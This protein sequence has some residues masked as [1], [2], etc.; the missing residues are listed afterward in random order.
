MSRSNLEK[1]LRFVLTDDQFDIFKSNA[2]ANA[3][4]FNVG[5]SLIE[6]TV[7][8]D[9]PNPLL[10]FY[11]KEIDGR[12]R[13]RTSRSG[14]VGIFENASTCPTHSILTWKQRIPEF[15]NSNVRIEKE[16]E[17]VLAPWEAKQMISILTEVLHCPRISSYERNRETFYTDNIEVA[18]DL[19]PYGHVVELELKSGEESSLTALADLLGLNQFAQSHLSCDDMYRL[20][21]KKADVEPKNDILFLDKSMPKLNDYLPEIID[22]IK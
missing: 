3:H 18:S 1:E 6:L 9:N 19:F 4:R 2:I 15:A 21:C 22:D 10:S 16:I 13:M 20:L 14:R 5:S 11:S 8:F 7:M 12:L 17:V